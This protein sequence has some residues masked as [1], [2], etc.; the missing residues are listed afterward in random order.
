MSNR[1]GKLCAQSERVS[2]RERESELLT[3]NYLESGFILAEA[4]WLWFVKKNLG[5]HPNSLVIHR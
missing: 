5:G 3:A 4:F 2:E 1:E